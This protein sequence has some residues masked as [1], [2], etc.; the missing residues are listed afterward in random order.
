MEAEQNERQPSSFQARAV[1]AVT[2]VYFSLLDAETAD[3]E[4]AR[5]RLSLLGRLIPAAPGTK[6]EPVEINGLDA[7]WLIP[8]GA[9]PGKAILY[10]HGGAYVLGG[11]DSHRHLAS[12]IARES[13]A[14]ALLP[15]YSLAPEYPFPHAIE[16]AVGVYRSLLDSGFSPGDLVI[17]G[18]SA[19][20]GLTVAT[21]LSL[22]DQGVPM[23]A[24][25]C[26][27]SPWLDLSASGESMKSREE[28]DPWF[29]PADIQVVSRHYCAADDCRN[30]LASPVFADVAGLP[31]TFIQVGDDEVLLSDATRFAEKLEA[32]GIPVEIEV[33]PEMWHVFQ[34]FLMI[35]PEAREAVSHIAL[36]IRGVL[37]I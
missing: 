2:S 6:V 12:H 37:A 29:T 19:G 34:A 24:G 36:K 18:D 10:L 17:A 13:G 16:D 4:A 22:R 20:G 15:E 26:L 5:K 35:V 25:A 21:L 30:P 32:A 3:V 11:C 1:R 9:P 23:P 14:R 7:E 28:R 33:W 27:L 8:D 31:P